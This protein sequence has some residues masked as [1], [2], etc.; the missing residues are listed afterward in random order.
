[1]DQMLRQQGY[2]GIEAE[3]PGIGAA[4]R[5]E[6]DGLGRAP[7]SRLISMY[8]GGEAVSIGDGRRPESRSARI[9]GYLPVDRVHQGDLGSELCQ[10]GG[11]GAAS[12]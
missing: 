10:S 2:A 4:V 6:D 11:R 7:T 12:H 1:M 9:L 5:G 8:L 3:R